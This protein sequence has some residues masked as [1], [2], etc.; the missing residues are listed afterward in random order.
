ME[1][2]AGVTINGI[3]R[4]TKC[5]SP[6]Q[7]LIDCGFYSLPIRDRLR[8]YGGAWG[9]GGGGVSIRPRRGGVGRGWGG[10]GGTTQWPVRVRFKLF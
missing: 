9:G 6:F 5:L 2:L 3:S 8:V 1:G 7:S 4:S 10:P